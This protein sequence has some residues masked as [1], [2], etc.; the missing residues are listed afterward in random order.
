M[1]EEER[2]NYINPE[3]AEEAKKKGNEFYSQGDYP[4]A[5]KHYNDAIRRN[6]D[7]PK[8]YSNRSACYT[9]L[10]EFHL[11]LSDAEQCIK[12]DPNFVKGYLRKGASL[13]AMKDNSKAAQVYRKAMELDPNCQEAID[14]YRKCMMAQDDPEVVKQRAMSDPEVKR[15]LEDPAM[16]MILQQM[17]A[18]P[19]AIRE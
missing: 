12:M 9:K 5:I 17:Q 8:L 11:A 7:D 14:S 19:N 6:P 10:M 16:H 18:D 15:I 3:L 13:V 2:K 1:K 4:E